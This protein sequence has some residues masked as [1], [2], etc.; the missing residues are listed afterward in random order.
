ML[1]SGAD[2]NTN[3]YNML[4]PSPPHLPVLLSEVLTILKSGDEYQ[5]HTLLDATLGAGGHS[6]ALLR[7]HPEMRHFLGVD[8]DPLA[9][10]IA[11]RRLTN[12]QLLPVEAQFWQTAFSEVAVALQAE[13]IFCDA[14][15]L[16]LGV[17][18]MQLDSESRGFSL[19]FNAPLDMRMDPSQSLTAHTI[20][21]K[22]SAKDL[23]RLLEAGD[24]PR[25]AQVAASICMARAKT[26]INTTDQLIAVTR[27][28]LGP[29]KKTHP[30]TLLFQA[31]R[32][33]VNSELIELGMALEQLTDRLTVGG[34]LIVIS[35]H[36]LEDR[37]V[38]FAFKE[39]SQTGYFNLLTRKPLQAS[40]EE[41]RANP[42][43]RSAKLRAIE[44]IAKGGA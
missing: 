7:E 33:S 21:N 28:K 13:K 6:E 34:K 41:R 14:I 30:A 42:K 23:A 25:P 18:S 26:P 8:R 37:L 39:L 44:K 17:S 38:K 40:R 27:S 16:D 4:I 15:I 5:L 12:S 29:R 22:F 2:T 3:K 43:S 31:L 1:Q 24:V 11:G 19:R 35:F 10:E 20:V 9:I 32:I 36:S